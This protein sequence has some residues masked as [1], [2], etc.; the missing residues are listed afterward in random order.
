MA[1]ITNSEESL[2]VGSGII[3]IAALTALVGS[4]TAESLILGDRGAIGMAWAAMS[5]FGSLF[6][7]RACLAAAIPAWLRETLGLNNIRSNAAVGVKLSLQRSPKVVGDPV[8]VCVLVKKNQPNAKDINNEEVTFITEEEIRQLD[9]YSR[10]L[11]SRCALVPKDRPIQPYIYHPVNWAKWTRIRARKDWLA[12][13]CCLVKLVESVVLYRAG[14]IRLSWVTSVSWF[15]FLLAALILQFTGLSREVG[16]PKAGAIRMDVVEGDIPRTQSRGEKRRVLLDIPLSVRQHMLWK[17]VWGFGSIVVG[18]SLIDLYISLT[19][20]SRKPVTFWAGFQTMWLAFRIVFYQ[21]ADEAVQKN[22]TVQPLSEIELDQPDMRARLLALTAVLNRQQMITHPRGLLTYKHDVTDPKMI[23]ELWHKASFEM[24]DNIGDFGSSTMG[25]IAYINILAV[26]G[27]TLL[28]SVSWMKGLS[29]DELD[30]YDCCLVAIGLENNH[31][32]LIPAVRVLGGPEP[33]SKTDTESITEPRF[34]AKGGTND[35]L[36]VFWVFWIPAGKNRW[37]YWKAGLDFMGK[38]KFEVLDDTE[39]TKRL[40]LGD[41]WISLKHCSEIKTTVKLSKTVGAS[42]RDM[43]RGS[44]PEK[45][46]LR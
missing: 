10:A 24:S 11:L 31:L 17:V 12:T 30:L 14:A 37:L 40:Q 21:L 35:G 19:R 41:L 2:G 29:Y 34:A 9:D 23:V 18:Y 27:D 36:H 25:D 39:V 15:Y 33:G 8:A 43:V 20:L 13:F 26:L 4:T 1:N 5:S 45:G 16:E 22:H 46:T 38:K 32:R 7:I 6:L 44:N 28:T 42:L 3:E